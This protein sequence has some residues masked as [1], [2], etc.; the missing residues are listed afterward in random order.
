MVSKQYFRK[1]L[2]AEIETNKN[3][4]YTDNWDY[5]LFGNTSNISTFKGKIN[6]LGRKVLPSTFY[7]KFLIDY[8][9]REHL[10]GMSFLYNNLADEYSK[11]LLIQVLTHRLIGHKKHKLPLSTKEYWENL[12][13]AE[14]LIIDKDD[15][16]NPK[17]L[18]FL[19]YKSDLRP[20]N[21]PITLYYNPLGI[22]ID[23]IVKQY[24]Y[25]QNGKIIKAEKGDVVI[26]AGACWGDTALFFASEVGSDGKVYSFEFI[27]SNIEIFNKN[28]DLNSHLSGTVKIVPS[29]LWEKSGQK[30][31]FTDFGPAS[32]VFTEKPETSGGE[33]ETLTIDD[34]VKREEIAKVDFIKMDIEGAEPFAV[35]GATDTI[36]KFKPKLAIAVYHKLS[37]FYT[38]AQY[39][40]S[41]DLGYKFYF[42]HATI[43]AGESVLFAEV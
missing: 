22:L 41:L 26:D 39:I 35:K 15:Y 43:H 1:L 18:D 20:I 12:K 30:L 27:P 24:E 17:F 2:K 11:N 13:L 29:P 23:F 6:K 3:N 4:N 38:I 28:L 33:T 5:V 9:L 19:L 36:V 8:H 34:F 16:I 40:Q 25:N 7:N 42:Q 14:N 37:D 32:R 31:Y 10:D 21:Y